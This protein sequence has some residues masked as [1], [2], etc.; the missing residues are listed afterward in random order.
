MK[1][2]TIMIGLLIILVLAYV[3]I[4]KV[5]TWMKMKE[6]DKTYEESFP[7]PAELAPE[8][9]GKKV[10]FHIKT[11][12]SVD[13]AQ[14]CE[15]FNVALA[16]LE[17]GADVDIIFSGSATLDFVGKKSRLE[18]TKIPERLRKIIAYQMHI[19]LK[20]IPYN[21]KDFLKLIHDRGA[22]MYIN[23]GFNV[24]IG[25]SDSLAD[26]NPG[27]GYIQ[28]VNYVEIPKI[29]DAGDVYVVY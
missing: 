16:A 18:K 2:T 17:A 27:Y 11:G 6:L 1:K 28:P 14:I 8:L 23:T 10:V 26:T 29:I 12:L 9:A 19:P 13:D 24:V 3:A 21:Y 25:A 5:P 4:A 22:N 15:A 20:E 7:S